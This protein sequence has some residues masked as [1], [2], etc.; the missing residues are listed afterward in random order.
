MRHLL[1]GRSARSATA[2]S[3]GGCT[4]SFVR[5][6]RTFPVTAATY[7]QP[8]GLASLRHVPSPPSVLALLR[9][10]GLDVRLPNCSP[11]LKDVLGSFGDDPAG[12]CPCP[13]AGDG[14]WQRWCSR[15]GP[16]SCA[17]VELVHG[18]TLSPLG[19]ER[20]GAGGWGARPPR[21]TPPALARQEGR[22]S[23][24]LNLEEVSREVSPEEG[25]Q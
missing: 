20:L 18:R 12:A 10:C 24:P 5:S 2:T 21:L 14:R 15:E 8:A 13:V 17:S 6:G 1:L 23:G 4:P 25:T 19:R 7:A 9:L 16:P 22:F 3:H 11:S